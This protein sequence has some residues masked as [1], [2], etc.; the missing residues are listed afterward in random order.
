MQK[1]RM[2]LTPGS[3]MAA[4]T[5]LVLAACGGPTPADSGMM[6]DPD[7]Y[8]ADGDGGMPMDDAYVPPD[9]DSGMPDV[10]AGMDAG[11]MT[12]CTS[13]MMVNRVSPPCDPDTPEGVGPGTGPTGLEGHIGPGHSWNSPGTFETGADWLSDPMGRIGISM[14]VIEAGAEPY[15]GWFYYGADGIWYANWRNRALPGTQGNHA[16]ITFSADHMTAT[17]EVFDGGSDTP[18]MTVP[19]WET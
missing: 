4:L 13:D 17:L 12:T 19:L 1:N 8:M 6:P 5:C 11:E 9:H 2:F 14:P 7:A 3:F 15:I 16:R 10:D 18:S